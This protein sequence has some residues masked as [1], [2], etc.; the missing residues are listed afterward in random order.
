MRKPSKK[1]REKFE[2]TR[3]EIIETA[4]ASVAP[5]RPNPNRESFKAG[6]R[7]SCF[8]RIK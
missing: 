8:F 3:H 4:K 2:G 5:V 6:P 7:P 1:A